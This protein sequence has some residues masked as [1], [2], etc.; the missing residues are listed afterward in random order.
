MN[1]EKIK[2]S[3]PFLPILFIFENSRPGYG[4]CIIRCE[5]V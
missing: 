4:G 2:I 3:L 1:N 5:L